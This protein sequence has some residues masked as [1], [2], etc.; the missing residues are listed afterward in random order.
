MKKKK[1]KKKEEGELERSRVWR[2]QQV[3]KEERSKK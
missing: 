3:T 2:K 1:E